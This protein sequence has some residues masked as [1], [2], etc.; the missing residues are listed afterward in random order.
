MLQAGGPARAPRR[1]PWPTLTGPRDWTPYLLLL[2]SAAFL[3]VFFVLPMIQAFGLALRTEGAGL[4]LLHLR[5]MARDVAFYPA[6]RTTVVLVLVLIPIQFGVALTMALLVQARLRGSS[7]FLYVFAI[8]LAV[9]DL[10][11]GIVW[12][13][14][15]TERGYLNTLLQAVGLV[16]RPYIFLNY[17]NPQML[18]LAIVLAEVWRATSIIMVILVAGLQSI[19]EEY[20]EAAE[21][22]GATLGQKVRRIILPLLKPSLQVALILRTILAFQVFATVVAI[23]GRGLTVLPA[24]AWR[25]YGAY[26]NPHVAAAYASLILALSI[27]A[28]LFYLW[29]LRSRHLELR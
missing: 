13:G 28:T 5:T 27:G 16:E 24:E 26:R 4:T 3:V 20:L 15:F 25:W 12:F 23:A 21:V 14:I 11:A 29:T 19:P 22:F 1:A 8:P 7:F 6:L 2:P 18:V 17:Q 9:S 10:A